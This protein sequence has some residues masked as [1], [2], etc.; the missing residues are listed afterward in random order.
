MIQNSILKSEELILITG[1]S[2]FVGTQVVSCLL[3]YG[4]NNLRCFV[5]PS[6]NLE[7]LDSIIKLHK[8]ANIELIKGNL[9][10]QKDCERAINGAELVYHLAAGRGKSFAGCFLDLYLDIPSSV[11]HQSYKFLPKIFLIPY[12][13][14]KR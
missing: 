11:L 6:S 12:Q 10:I 5:R 1:A 7:R 13:S 9:L 8:T 14:Q 3:S 2:G 4:Y